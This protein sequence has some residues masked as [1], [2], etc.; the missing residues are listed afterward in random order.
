ML[1]STVLY[2]RVFIEVS[3]VDTSF[4]P[5]VALPLGIMLGFAMLTVGAFWWWSHRRAQGDFEDTTPDF[6]ALTEHEEDDE[7]SD[8]ERSGDGDEPPDAGEESEDEQPD[9]GGADSE[10]DGEGDEDGTSLAPKNPAELPA[11]LIFAVIYAVV[12][13]AVAAVNHYLDDS[14]LYLVALVSGLTDVDAITLSTSRL[15]EKGRIEADTGWR[16]I[17]VGAM[18][19]LVFK[20]G[21]CA[22]LGGRRLTLYIGV[23]FGASIVLGTVLLFVL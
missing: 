10:G 21:I 19:N 8:A 13:F 22:V 20:G 12:K 3:A 23:M 4:L 5:A 9:A 17:L 1:A 15:V 18:A 16:L 2:V 11:A 6:S 7:E 14:W